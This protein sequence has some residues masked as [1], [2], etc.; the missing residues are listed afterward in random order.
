MIIGIN[1]YIGSGK[2]TVGKIIQYI[3]WC[4]SV[5]S[6]DLPAFDEYFELGYEQHTWEVK[7][8]AYKLKQIASLLTGI[9]VEKFE[10]QEFKK[11]YLGPEW[12][13]NYRLPR[14]SLEQEMIYYEE[15]R[16]T[17]REF[18]QKLGTEAIRDGLHTNAWVNALF[19]DYKRTFLIGELEI[20][21]LEEIAKERGEY[22]NWIIT[23]CRFPN[24]AQ[25]IKDR[26]GIVVRINRDKNGLSV[27]SPTGTS[28]DTRSSQVTNLHP[29]ET[30]LDDWNFD[31]IIE[32]NG[33]I[34][35]L[36]HKTSEML[37]EFKII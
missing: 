19:A 11:T 23:D 15:R 33:T 22:P 35:A 1:G 32:N 7:K 28:Y 17:V 2:D 3:T 9:P 10:D 29:S 16:M 37:K 12:N 5:N 25:A 13:Y 20:D 30:S 36:V 27:K 6:S 34:E 18:L 24:E 26:G 4:N 8:F 14:E 21:R 31:Y